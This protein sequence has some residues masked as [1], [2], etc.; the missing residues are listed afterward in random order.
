MRCD[1]HS[2]I[3]RLT[4]VLVILA[5]AES[6]WGDLGDEMRQDGI[7]E[8]VV[9]DGA[10]G[11]PLGKADVEVR[12]QDDVPLPLVVSDAEGAASLHVEPG[13]Y[14][15]VTA[16]YEGY[17]YEG[18]PQAVMVEPGAT[19][20]VVLALTRNG[21]GVV[22]DLAGMPIAGVAVRV[23]GAGREQVTS[24]GQGRFEFAWDRRCHLREASAFTL[25][26]RQEQRNLAALVEVREGDVLEVKVQPG[27]TLTGRIVD[28]N[29]RAIPSAWVYAT[30]NVADWG[31]T[32]L[33]NE[34]VPVDSNGVFEIRT[35][36]AGGRYILH[37]YAQGYGSREVVVENR[38]VADLALDLGPLTLAPAR[39]SV[40]G[41][42]VDARNYPV[43]NATIY[44]WGAGQ[45]LRLRTET[46]ADGRF[47]LTGVCAGQID[48]RVDADWG[49]NNRLRAHV[50]AN[51][52]DS[53]VQITPLY[54]FRK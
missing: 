41:R 44:G 31:E 33:R 24:D 14:R 32:P 15:I 8:I 54:A 50:Y 52:G 12:R 28:P 53:D 46:D 16:V 39:L 7:L 4:L 48:L 2:A 19:K 37:A 9:A 51:G 11:R 38:V 6:G 23:I 30:L 25:M 13:A 26:A 17:T 34:Q 3:G 10:S 47:L 27:A 45:P 22:R 35:V 18:L 5:S 29:G 40:A 43:P 49:G 36:P 21:H 20:R 42:V 1:S